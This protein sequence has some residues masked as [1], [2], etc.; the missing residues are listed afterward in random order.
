[1]A[2]IPD[3]ESRTIS[4]WVQSR[5]VGS[6]A[7]VGL[8]LIGETASVLFYTENLAGDPVNDPVKLLEPR[9]YAAA[10]DAQIV[11]EVDSGGI[12]DGLW[13]VTARIE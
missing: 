7:S 12:D 1:M 11:F 13:F 5:S 8:P 2:A 10:F 3:I 9:V 4:V 6:A